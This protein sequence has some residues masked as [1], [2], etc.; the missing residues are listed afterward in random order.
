VWRIAGERIAVLLIAVSP[1][2]I[3]ISGFHGNTD[4]VR[5]VSSGDRVSTEHA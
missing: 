2:N 3:L 4:P 5:A 1:I